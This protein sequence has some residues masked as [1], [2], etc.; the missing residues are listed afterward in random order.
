[1]L[2]VLP[3][4]VELT[5]GLAAPLPACP[6]PR[7]RFLPRPPLV[8]AVV[9]VSLVSALTVLSAAVLLALLMVAHLLSL[10]TQSSRSDRW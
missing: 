10:V 6:L 7:P 2:G 5:L 8:L 9:L 4:N 1:M 3:L